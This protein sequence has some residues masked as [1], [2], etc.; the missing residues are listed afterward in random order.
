MM[1]A[2]KLLAR[3][4]ELGWNAEELSRRSGV[5][6]GTMNKIL[7][8][9]TRQPS[10]PA[11]YKLS[12]ALRLSME[13]LL[14]DRVPVQDQWMVLPEREAVR[15]LSQREMELLDGFVSLTDHGQQLL[16]GVLDLLL[17]QAP[18]P[19]FTGEGRELLCFRAVARGR[20]GALGTGF[21][22][23]RIQVPLAPVTR[24]AEFAV[25]L[26]SRSLVPAFGPGTILALRQGQPAM[27]QLGLFLVDRELFVRKLHRVRG[28]TKLTAIAR[29]FKDILLEE[30]TE[31]Q[32]LGTVLGAV[33]EYRWL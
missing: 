18:R 26:T 2:E 11:V 3:K 33:R 21:S 25:V 29:E 31:Y 15:Y 12:Q 28:R 24:E 4:R 32:C 14:D 9:Q 17:A 27:D 22:T 20:R 13:Y 6:L 8:G 5:P 23:R 7:S 19:L 30:G 10:A 16:E 1:L